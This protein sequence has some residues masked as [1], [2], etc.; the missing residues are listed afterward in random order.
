[1]AEGAHEVLLPFGRQRLPDRIGRPLAHRVIQASAPPRI[2]LA[3]R[4]SEIR[5]IL[6]NYQRCLVWCIEEAFKN[7]KQ[8]LAI[9]P[10]FHQDERRIE[11]HIFIAFLAYC[12][13]ITLTAACMPWRPG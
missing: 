9:R 13:Q 11:A 1:M 10:V 6:S 2:A 4:V 3:D 12:M 5:R 7:L 8:D